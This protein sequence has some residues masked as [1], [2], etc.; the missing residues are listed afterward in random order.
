MMWWTAPTLRHRCA[1]GWLRRNA[2]T[3]RRAVH[4]RGSTIGVD[5][6]KSVF[7]VH[8]VDADGTVVIRRR[9]GRAK[10]LEF[11]SKLRPCLVGMEACA[12]AHH[13]ARELKKLGHDA[14]LM[15]PTYVKA[16]LKRGK[17]DAADAAAICE[18]VT[19]PSMRFVPI[20][21]VEQQSTL[22]LHRTRDLLI[23]QRTQLINALRA[24]LAELGLVAAK[25]REGLCQLVTVV[26]E[27]G[28]ERL[29]CNA[30]FACQAIVGQLHAV[31]T[32]ISGLDKRI[33]QTHRANPDSKRLDAIPGFG[34]ILS[35]AVV[36]TM[37][38]P[39][40][41]KTGREFAA[42]IGLVPRQNST[43]GKDRLGSI[44]KQGDRYLRRLLVVGAIS[45]VRTARMWPDKYPWVIELLGR[46]PAKVVAVAL[47][48][49]MARVAW[50][51]LAKGET[52][53]APTRLSNAAI[54]VAA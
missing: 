18:A 19:R 42:W 6:A 22:M 17:N 4:G 50:A 23:R 13:W 21:S 31:Q 33:T 10:V 53:R 48:N 29:P 27:C 26:T 49:K 36:A 12:T 5:I 1:I 30:R 16:Y 45:I 25:G 40:A 2:T 3:L 52:Y 28:D 54:T 41:F 43:G 38:D 14:R 11:F 8:G 44:S 15:P 39:K 37:T 46:R 34:V 24:H 35:T 51:V 32:Q 9:V 20:K 7:Q 47:A